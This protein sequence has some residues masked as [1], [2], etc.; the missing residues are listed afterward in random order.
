MTDGRADLRP[1]RL[2]QPA[3]AHPG[4]IHT[5]LGTE[6]TLGQLEV[7]HL[8]GEEQDRLATL[9]GRVGHEAEGERRLAHAGP[10]PDDD[11][12]GRLQAGE[13]LV[14][15][16]VPGRDAGDGVPPV[17]QRLQVVEGAGQQIPN[18]G[19]G[20]DAPA[21]GHLE[22]HGLGPVHGRGDVVRHLVAQLG[23]HAD[24]PAQERVLLDDPCVAT[25]VGDGRGV[26]LQ[27]D[28]GR[29]PAD[30][31]QQARPPQLVSD[32]DRVGR[33]TLGVQGG[34]GVEDVTVGRLVEILRAALLDSRGDRIPREDHRPQQR[35]L[36]LEVVRRNSPCGATSPPAAGVVERL[37]HGRQPSPVKPVGR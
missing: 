14:E 29:R 32:R 1:V 2:Q 33:L 5:R 22:H 28:Q 21:L 6:Q 7:A 19:D 36:G 9:H 20:V 24:H 30:G 12:V 4:G 26:G 34:D 13:P 17:V 15:V 10:G 25:G 8:Q 31:V 16:V 35:L 27:R 18:R 3:V 23:R 37:N 11:E